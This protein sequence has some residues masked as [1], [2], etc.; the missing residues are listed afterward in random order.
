MAWGWDSNGDSAMT[1]PVCLLATDAHLIGGLSDTPAGHPQQGTLRSCR[2]HCP[3][4]PAQRKRYSQALGLPAAPSSGART[5]LPGGLLRS[6]TVPEELSV[7]AR[8]R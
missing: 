4:V 1:R 2:G 3:Q 6:L 8:S 5:G 7:M